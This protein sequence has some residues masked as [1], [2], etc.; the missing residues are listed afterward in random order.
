MEEKTILVI[1]DND[2]N[3]QLMRA[4]LQRGNYRILEADNAEAGIRLARAH[5]PDLILM[6]I[7]LPGMDG[8]SATRIIKEEPGM[9]HIPIL[10]M[11]GLAMQSDMDKAT[12]VGFAGYIV[13]PTSVKTILE[14]IA[15]HI[16][17]QQTGSDTTPA[18]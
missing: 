3:M 4:I 15:R 2:I 5:L 9:K 10:A 11:T 8:L 17:D 13:K 6:D 18:C 12:Q 16:H 1:E 7:Q 14:I